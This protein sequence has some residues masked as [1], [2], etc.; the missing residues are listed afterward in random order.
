MTSELHQGKYINGHTLEEEIGKGGF[1]V[2]WK[3]KS[4]EGD[5]KA[6]KFIKPEFTEYLFKEAQALKKLNHPN[7][8]SIEEVNKNHSFPY[9]LMECCESNLRKYIGNL[10]LNKIVE[11]V[12]KIANAVSYSHSQGI[13]HGDRKK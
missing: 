1:G 4:D 9:I 13:I 10:Q 5:E 8:I 12:G 11:V 2:V 3:V 6:M 7:I